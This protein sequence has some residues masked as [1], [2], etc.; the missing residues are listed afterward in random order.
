MI[1]LS[2]KHEMGS[3]SVKSSHKSSPADLR[4]KSSVT[5]C[6]VE[7]QSRKGKTVHVC[8]AAVCVCMCVAKQFGHCLRLN[9]TF[10]SHKPTHNNN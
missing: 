6:A 10:E 4:Q 1:S 2:R 8:M 9:V 3:L 5:K 7:L